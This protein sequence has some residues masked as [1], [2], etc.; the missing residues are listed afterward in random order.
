ML[1][2][3]KY[4]FIFVRTFKVGS[5]SITRVL[6]PYC[7][8][9]M[10][11][12]AHQVL[13]K[14]GI[15]DLKPLYGKHY[16]ASQLVDMMGYERFK[17][18]FSFTVVRNPWDWNVSLYK[19][20]LRTTTHRQHESVK[21]MSGFDEFIR[22]K[23]SIPHSLQKDFIYSEKGVKL[24]DY[25]ARFETLSEDFNKICQQI[26]IKPKR[27]PNLNTSNRAHYRN[28]YTEETREMVQEF[29]RRDIELF[30]YSF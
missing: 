1:K 23:C 10:K 16:K 2:S 20:M 22:L 18:Y 8:N 14:L 6:L 24:V 11:I 3:D 17:S 12:F 9:P 13:R 30:G 7:M 29:Y 28:Y 25:V 15:F 19:Y 4:N 21:N 27:L 5:T 26:G